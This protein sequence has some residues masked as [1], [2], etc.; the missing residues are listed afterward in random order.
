MA[1]FV[2]KR[3]VSERF[4]DALDA[5]PPFFI[6]CVVVAIL[7]ALVW[8]IFTTIQKDDAS[9]NREFLQQLHSYG[10]DA[11]DRSAAITQLRK[12][13]ATALIT[14]FE[15][16]DDLI[17][18]ELPDDQKEVAETIAQTGE[19]GKLDVTAP[20]FL[21]PVRSLTFWLRVIA[22]AYL[23][24][25]VIA[26][27]YMLKD[28]PHGSRK[29]RIADLDWNRPTTWLAVTV[30]GP[31]FWLAILGS[32]LLLCKDAYDRRMAIVPLPQ[33]I[34]DQD[35]TLEF[36]GGATHPPACDAPR[37]TGMWFD[38]DAEDAVMPDKEIASYYKSSPVAAADTYV[39]LRTNGALEWSR[40]KLKEVD[41]KIDKKKRQMQELGQSLRKSQSRLNELRAERVR[42]E[43]ATTTVDVPETLARQEFE[44]MLTLPG[45]IA[46]QSINDRLRL[47]VRAQHEYEGVGY[48][49]GDWQIDI[50]IDTHRIF[51]LELRSGVRA[52]WYPG[53]Y[54]VYRIS[55]GFCFGS[56]QELIEE[57]LIKAQY[58]EAMA[59]A[60]ECLSGV[61]PEDQYK[62]PR[63]F[64]ALASKEES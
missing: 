16:F 50:G 64:N 49:L 35:V 11:D 53:D 10:A 31:V 6:I 30:G 7:Y 24:V 14:T 38:D 23:I 41:R 33:V 4:D 29:S 26:M 22:I 17:E 9:A 45:V 27:G 3:R 58:P 42:V 15:R 48:D 2:H 36:D 43:A 20:A 54:P 18:D 62:V 5:G 46:A 44:R 25:T 61:N 28:G 34:Q 32:F 60:V 21:G 55:G 56:R 40:S 52:D 39:S 51:A 59:L 12:E 1:I 8:G 57:H 19:P 63:A 37:M 47:I 13:T